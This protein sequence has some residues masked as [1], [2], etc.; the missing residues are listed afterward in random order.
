[1]LRQGAV[2]LEELR[3]VVPETL[4]TAPA[5]PAEPDGPAP[6]DVEPAE[7]AGA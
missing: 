1:V 2:T 6:A 5:A 4:G 7:D 3:E